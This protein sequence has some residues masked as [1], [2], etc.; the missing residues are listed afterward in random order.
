[1]EIGTDLLVSPAAEVPVV[2]GDVVSAIRALAARRIGKRT[3]AREVGVSINT[4]RRYLRQPIPAG[5][6]VRAPRRWS[7]D[8]QREARTLYAGIAAGNA[9]VVRRLL[10][11]R[12]L[13][14]SERTIQRAVADLRRE[15]RAAALA[16]SASKPHR[17]SSCRSISGRNGSRSPVSPCGSSCWW[18]SSVTRVGSS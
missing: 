14:V 3:I 11:D 9:V 6:Q 16:R 5:H 2:D 17:V 13:D 10:A 18:R 8:W 15:Q 1:M 4:V 7:A 12:G